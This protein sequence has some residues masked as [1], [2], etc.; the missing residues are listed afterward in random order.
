MQNDYEKTLE[1]NLCYRGENEGMY[2]EI[3]CPVHGRRLIRIDD[4]NN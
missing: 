3:F 2:K 4:L 1:E